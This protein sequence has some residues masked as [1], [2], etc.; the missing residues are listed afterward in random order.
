[1]IAHYDYVPVN[2]KGLYRAGHALPQ[3]WRWR[4]VGLRRNTS[5]YSWL[6]VLPSL[7][8]VTCDTEPANRYQQRGSRRC[9]AN[10]KVFACACW[11]VLRFHGRQWVSIACPP[12]VARVEVEFKA[13][14][15]HGSELNLGGANPAGTE[16]AHIR[17]SGT[18]AE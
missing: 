4:K 1:M 14:I 6:A 15:S 18:S 17:Q 9:N 11:V 12:S 16:I 5:S 13:T 7:V 8:R 2:D 10:V 3:S